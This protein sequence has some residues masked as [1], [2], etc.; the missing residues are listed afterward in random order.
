MESMNDKEGRSEFSN[1]N[2][3]YGHCDVRLAKECR[4]GAGS[5]FVEA[6][7]HGHSSTYHTT[8]Y[9]G[10]TRWNFWREMDFVM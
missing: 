5:C 6:K 4:G 7:Y 1:E 8:S 3:S 2:R 9:E 10:V